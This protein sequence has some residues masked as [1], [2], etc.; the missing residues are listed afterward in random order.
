[1]QVQLRDERGLTGSLSW[2]TSKY[3]LQEVNKMPPEV[4]NCTVME[5]FYNQSEICHAAAI[6]VGSAHP[7]CETQREM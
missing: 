4:K 6:L 1:M 5:C 7:A 3:H 2:E